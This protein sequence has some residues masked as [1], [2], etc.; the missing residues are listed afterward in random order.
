MSRRSSIFSNLWSKAL[1]GR[2]RK[3]ASPRP[4]RTRLQ[5]EYLEDRVVPAVINVNSTAD[6]ALTQL[7]PGQVTLREAI[8]MANTNG[9]ASNT[10]NL[11]VAGDYQLKLMG[12]PGEID[13]QAGELAIFTNATTTQNGLSLTITNTS[14]GSV[15]IDGGDHVRVLDINPNDKIPTTGNGVLGAVTLNGVTIENGLAQ[16]G[17]GAGGSGAGIRDQGPVDLTLTNC[18]V[19]SSNATADGG[20]ISMENTAS[21]PWVLTLNNS[22]V[23]GNCAGDAGGG[24]ETDGSGKIVIDSSII[25]NNTCVNQGAGIWLDAIATGNTFQTANLTVTNSDIDNNSAGMLGGGI[26]NAGNGTVSIS[27]STVENNSSTGNGGGFGDV[28]QRGTLNIQN[29]LILNNSAGGNGGGVAAGGTSTTINNSEFMGN[30]AGVNGGRTVGTNGTGVPSAA[31]Q[32]S[33][34]GLFVNGSGTLTLTNTTIEDSTASVN[35]GGIQ[36]ATSGASTITNST[37][38]FNTALFNTPSATNPNDG[39]GIDASFSGTAPLALNHD[40]ITNNFGANGGGLYY[41]GTSGLTVQNTIIASNTVSSVGSD[42]DFVAAPAGVDQG[43]NLIG[44]S[45]AGS[46]NTG[47]TAATTQTGTVAKPLDPMLTNPQNNGGP[48]AGF[49][50]TADHTGDA[51]IVDTEAL[52]PGSPAFGKGVSSTLT[53]DERG[54]PRGT[55][56]DIGAFQFQNAALAVNISASSPVALNGTET[57]K[58]TV[59]NTSN[60]PLPADNGTLVVSAT[61]GLNIGGTQTFTLGALAAGQSATFTVNATGAALGTQT[62]F[63][64]V[65]TPDTTPQTVTTSVNVT[66]SQTAPSTTPVGTLTLFAFG[67]GPTGLDGFEVDTQG[68]IFAQGIGLG[69]L[70]GSPIFLGNGLSF[71]VLQFQNGALLGLMETGGH[72]FLV[73]VFENFFNPFILPALLA[74]LHI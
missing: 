12:T 3:P 22:Q 67:F 23:M 52:M 50:G 1:I 10:I 2:R 42:V 48:T 65:T 29:S 49:M 57:V 15:K 14:G 31:L 46:G 13:N 71:P 64:T 18:N 54:F 19:V 66:V 21:T 47:F 37:I 41:A 45:G 63:A 62:V 8:Q 51:A 74:G 28:N 69:G 20:G 27:Q 32:G 72:T 34:G 9:D 33:G 30:N 26:G 5:L 25:A 38:A 40:T 39:G 17:D 68:D 59:T 58:I 73:D 16:P 24:V 53:T 4:R 6:V 35:G 44:I 7:A 70:S 55:T 61:G 43:G 56:P 36:L 11:T 60:N